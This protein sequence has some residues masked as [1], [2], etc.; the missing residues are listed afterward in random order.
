MG[1]SATN[2]NPSRGATVLESR[3]S[4]ECVTYPNSCTLWYVLCRAPFAGLPQPVNALIPAY[5][6]HITSPQFP[7]INAAGRVD[8]SMTARCVTGGALLFDLDGTLART[9]HLHHEAYRRLLPDLGFNAASLDDAWFEATIAGRA[10]Q[11]V[12][13]RLLPAASDAEV[14][15]MIHR[16]EELWRELAAASCEPLEGLESLLSAAVSDSIPVVVVTNAPRDSACHLI[17]CIGLTDVLH[18]GASAEKPGYLVCGNE[19][20]RT[21]P[22]PDPY[23]AGLALLGADPEKSVAF[24]DSPTGVR[25]AVAAGIATVGLLTTTTKARLTAEGAALCV[26]HYS[27]AGAEGEKLAQLLRERL[28][29][30]VFRAQRQ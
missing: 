28:G 22:D 1:Q 4:F 17:R 6:V 8:T 29:W 19:C 23:L 18:P 27:H 7:H 13:K 15:A 10:N 5:H 9:D 20:N 14:Q 2:A 16:K 11:D 24:E 25:A 3:S 21:K 30:E 12:W 26:E